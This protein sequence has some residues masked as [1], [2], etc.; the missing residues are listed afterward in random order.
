MD[1]LLELDKFNIKKST[2]FL[3]HEYEINLQ[4]RFPGEATSYV[5]WK[6]KF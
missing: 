3:N 6:I 2:F 4:K 5:L 1:V